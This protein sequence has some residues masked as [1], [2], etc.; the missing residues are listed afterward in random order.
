MMIQDSVRVPAGSRFGLSIAALLLVAPLASSRA[1][2][3]LSSQG[4]GF[5]T[6]QLSSRAYGAGGS[7]AEIDPLSPVKPE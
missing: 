5:P 4:F 1:Q 7:L 2:S 6:G 3:N